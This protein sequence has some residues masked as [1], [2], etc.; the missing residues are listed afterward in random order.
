MYPSELYIYELQILIN[1]YSI[2][3]HF[4]TFYKRFLLMIDYPSFR[5][6]VIFDV[7]QFR[8]KIEIKRQLPLLKLSHPN[9]SVQAKKESTVF[10]ITAL[11]KP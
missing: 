3:N 8:N 6:H 2:Y 9:M 4:Q 1:R 5:E 11:T 7:S 10:R